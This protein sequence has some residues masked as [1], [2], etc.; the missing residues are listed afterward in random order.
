MLV[1]TKKQAEKYGSTIPTNAL[2]KAAQQPT[3]WSMEILPADTEALLSIAK[4]DWSNRPTQV[5]ITH[6]E[7][8]NY[9]DVIESARRLEQQGINSV[10]HLAVR[11]LAHSIN[12]T[13]VIE[14][15]QDVGVQEVLLLGGNAKQ[16]HGQYQQVFDALATGL[17][18]S[19]FT[20]L[21]FAG[22]PEVHPEIDDISRAYTALESKI[23]Y[24]NT[25]GIPCRVVSQ[26]CF[27]S[28]PILAFL[29]RLHQMPATT[30]VHI[31][32]A[33]NIRLI[34]LMKYSLMCGVGSSIRFLE[35][36]ASNLTGLASSLFGQYDSSALVQEIITGH[37]A[38]TTQAI[39]GLHQFAF[40]DYKQAFQ[41]MQPH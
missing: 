23:S 7:H 17:F 32:I 10:P 29:Q 1:D 20:R 18:D 11:N 35:N 37:N 22:F 6:L 34:K 28:E 19:G 40:G 25:Q 36:K 21:H 30:E 26:F 12:L 14:Q 31:G 33:G 8:S 4:A 3:A 38:T 16:P 41:S 39:N 9:T 15:M 13:Q 5:Y 27:H 2:N 24:A